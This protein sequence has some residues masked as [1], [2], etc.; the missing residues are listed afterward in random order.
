MV[1]GVMPCLGPQVFRLLIILSAPSMWDP[2]LFLSQEPGASSLS[3][4]AGCLNAI[5]DYCKGL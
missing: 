4:A 3:K 1:L 5:I 2:S